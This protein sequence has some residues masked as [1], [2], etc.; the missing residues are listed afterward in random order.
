M[1]H[2]STLSHIVV[3]SYSVGFFSPIR[4]RVAVTGFIFVGISETKQFID[5]VASTRAVVSESFKFAE[6]SFYVT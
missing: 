6:P 5:T 3:D 4:Q 1:L 2:P